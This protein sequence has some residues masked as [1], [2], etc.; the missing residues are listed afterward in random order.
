MKITLGGKL[1]IAIAVLFSASW[2]TVAFA[3]PGAYHVQ[4]YGGYAVYFL[5]FP[6]AWL[7]GLFVGGHAG[8]PWHFYL[9]LLLLIPNMFVLGYSIAGVFHVL[10]RVFTI[11]TPNGM[12]NPCNDSE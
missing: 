2:L 3:G 4:V 7:S 10:R 9:Y 6:L 8:L 11:S 5:S 1:S 12:I